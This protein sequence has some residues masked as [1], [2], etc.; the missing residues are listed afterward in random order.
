VKPQDRIAWIAAVDVP[1]DA[2]IVV[3]S[4]M[5]LSVEQAQAIEEHVLKALPGRKVI[6]LPPELELDVVRE[7]AS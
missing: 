4:E 2:V 3:K 7:V 6:V 5:H 1:S